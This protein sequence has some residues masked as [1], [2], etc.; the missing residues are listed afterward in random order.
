MDHWLIRQFAIR[1]ST[2]QRLARL[3]DVQ[4]VSLWDYLRYERS[5][6]MAILLVM[7]CIYIVMISHGDKTSLKERTMA[8][9][10]RLL[11]AYLALLLFV[12]HFHS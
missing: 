7:L 12:S 8:K 4:T 9:R 3:P 2:R 1:V 11:I 5:L 10:T 6:W